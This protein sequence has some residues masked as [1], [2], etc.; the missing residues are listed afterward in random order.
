LVPE[1]TLVEEFSCSREHV[2]AGLIFGPILTLPT[3]DLTPPLFRA[4]V[5]MQQRW[6]EKVVG[7][8]GGRNRFSSLLPGRSGENTAIRPLEL[9]LTLTAGFLQPRMPPIARILQRIR[10]LESVAFVPSVVGDSS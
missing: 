2:N 6:E 5:D 8:K 1:L 10:S 3:L 9:F 7:R 4:A